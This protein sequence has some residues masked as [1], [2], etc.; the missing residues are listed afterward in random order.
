CAD[1]K[2]REGE[3]ACGGT[4]SRCLYLF[5]LAFC[6]ITGGD[7]CRGDRQGDRHARDAGDERSSCNPTQPNQSS[8]Q[9]EAKDA[10][11]TAIR[12]AIWFFMPPLSVKCARRLKLH[13]A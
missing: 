6:P 9:E 11:S 4:S 1:G 13:D 5:R 2:R 8:Q 10:G 3:T 12:P 7:E